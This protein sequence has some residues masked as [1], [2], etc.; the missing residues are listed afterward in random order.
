MPPAEDA[1]MSPAPP[2]SPHRIHHLQYLQLQVPLVGVVDPDLGYFE[3]IASVFIGSGQ[4][5]EGIEKKSG[6]RTESGR[7][8]LSRSGC[9]RNHFG[10]IAS[11]D[12]LI[13]LS[14]YTA[15]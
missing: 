6:F 13:C 14:F 8:S 9:S 11:T 5:P 3:L 10:F 7:S 2:S 4:N 1:A 15:K 12:G